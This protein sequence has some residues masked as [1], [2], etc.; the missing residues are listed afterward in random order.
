MRVTLI[1]ADGGTD[2]GTIADFRPIFR[3][4]SQTTGMVFDLK[5]A[6]SYSTAVE[7]MCSGTTDVAFLGPAT[8]VQAHARGCADLLAVGVKDGKSVYHAIILVRAASPVR[9]VGALA[10][11]SLAVGDANSA[12]SFFFPLNMIRKAGVDPV[13]DLGALHITGSHAASLNAVASGRADA[14][15]MSVESYEKA[16]RARVASADDFRIIAMS[17]PIPYPPLAVSSRVG[18][19]RRERLRKAF[20]AIGAR[21]DIPRGSIRGYGGEQLDAYDANVSDRHYDAV[22]MAMLR[23]DAGMQQA[24]REKASVGRR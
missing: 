18:A 13:R 15:A 4:V 12:S 8:Y 20:G 6:S 2:N 11:R 14:A 22:R 16:L 5:V 7:A 24:L 10:G 21:G 3:A 1:P 19:A 17:E 23:I 9:S